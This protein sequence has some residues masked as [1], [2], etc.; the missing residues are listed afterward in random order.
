MKRI[1]LF[2]FF[3]LY[4][5]SVFIST[6]FANRDHSNNRD[7]VITSFGLE[8]GLPQST[9]N[10]LL[11]SSDG[12]LW[13]GTHG[14]LVRFDGITFRVFDRF[15]TPALV[16]DRIITLFE[17]SN[18]ALWIGSETGG[19]TQKVD[20]EFITI[21]LSMH[22]NQR[23]VV[24]ITEDLQNNIWVATSG[25]GVIRITDGT[26]S[27][28][29]TDDGLM[30]NI[31]SKIYRGTDGTIYA[32]TGIGISTFKEDK[33]E[34]LLTSDESGITKIH[35]IYDEG[36]DSFWLGTRGDGLYRVKDDRIERFAEKDGLPSSHISE[37]FKDSQGYLWIATTEGIVRYH[38]DI[39]TPYTNLLGLSDNNVLSITEDHEGTIWAGT[40]TGGL[41]KLVAA[42][43]IVIRDDAEGAV[44]NITSISKARDGSLWFGRNCGGVSRIINGIIIPLE[45]PIQ[46]TCV[47]SVL[48]DS[49][50]RLWIGTWGNG[51]YLFENGELEN[52][53]LTSG[54]PSNVVL[55][56]F[57]DKKGDI[58]F[59]T[60]F[61][62][63]IHYNNKSFQR[64]GPEDGLPH[65]DVRVIYE[66]VNGDYWFGT[67][68]GPV[69]FRNGTFQSFHESHPA[70]QAPVRTIYE[71]EDGIVWFGTYGA[72]LIQYKNNNFSV[73]S[74]DHGLKD[75]LISQLL[76]DEEGNFWMG[77]NRGIHRVSR[78]ALNDLANGLT[79]SVFSY[80]FGTEQG[81]I[82]RET[83]GGFQPS[84]HRSSDGKLWFPTIEGIAMIDP[85]NIR[86]SESPPPVIIEEVIADQQ[87]LQ[88]EEKIYINPGVNNFSIRFTALSFIS[89]ER[90]EFK[91]MLEGFD[92]DWNNIGNRREEFYTNIP[93]G[94]YIFRVI[95]SNHDGIWNIDG[96]VLT[97]HVLPSYWQTGWFRLVTGLFLI[98]CIAGAVFYTS[99]R[100]LKHR[101][102][103]MKQQQMVERERLR[104]A[105]DMHD[106]LGSRLTEIKLLGELSN[107][108]DIDTD[109]LR[110][111][112]R[113]MSEASLDVIE[114]FREIVWSVN[115]QNDSLENFIDYIT[116]FASDFFSRAGIRC[117]F[118]QPLDIPDCELSSDLRHHLL[119]VYKEICTNIVKHSGADEVFIELRF[120]DN[121]C[122]ITLIDN[123]IGFDLEKST[124]KGSG[125]LNIQKRVE[126]TK[127]NCSIQSKQGNGSK[128]QFEFPVL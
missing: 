84:A 74:T 89:P 48:E 90:I 125:L 42:N 118:G 102:E 120:S 113:D 1:V 112:L 71:D 109:Q 6:G 127:G 62:G 5:Y 124:G 88:L 10:S 92:S 2:I 46:N 121:M 115:P 64:Y 34:P 105:Q 68:K 57:E 7:Y 69:R 119:M 78:H 93:P 110:G 32:I 81:L 58:W 3:T 21:D 53:S 59:G 103:L 79:E 27:H 22:V 126:L 25:A 31:I 94:D 80:S 73:F 15:N 128:V 40:R 41:N 33:F 63:V 39:F 16:S 30:H 106:E 18:G 123:G 14:G 114:T 13:I 52:Y 49:K 60:P 104:I 96:A 107:R 87:R 43:I 37:V 97:I 29:T 108:D 116:Q 44:N 20:G 47:W 99:T 91:S 8:D 11:Q 77:S 122:V 17:D 72:G 65:P 61:N 56:I 24:S 9:V 76:E 28:Y 51:I 100:K 36:K 98:A 83:N 82:S 70:L 19:L 101:I 26:I 54:F 117:R 86:I 4:S 75:N 111:R 35:F 23:N 50:N 95:A 66:A 55:S 85:L 38:N 45:I 12:Y 67:F